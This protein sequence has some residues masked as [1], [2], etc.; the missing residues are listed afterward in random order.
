MSSVTKN[1]EDAFSDMFK[2]GTFDAKKMIDSILADI[3]RLVAKLAVADLG[4]LL[5]G[6]GRS[7][8]SVLGEIFGSSGGGGASGL[9]GQAATWIGGLFSAKGNAFTAQGVQAFAKGG[10]FSNSIVRQ[11]TLFRF[12]DGV[13]MMG[14][15][16]P[17]AIMPLTRD[18]QG[19]LGVRYEGREAPSTTI[20]S[21]SFQVCRVKQES[22]R[23]R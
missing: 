19:R 5:T 1:I 16:G 21:K 20:T 11:P 18:S 10:A 13:G 23:G 6:K 22:N 8:G 15:A 17:E 9:L 12:A 2:T 7:S 4:N 3:G 14:E